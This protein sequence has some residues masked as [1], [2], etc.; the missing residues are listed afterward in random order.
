[1]IHIVYIMH[2]H[3]LCILL[4]LWILVIKLIHEFYF[5]NIITKKNDLFY[6]NSLLFTITSLP[7]TII[8]SIIAPYFISTKFKRNIC[9]EQRFSSAVCIFPIGILITLIIRKYKYI[10]IVY[11][12]ILLLLILSTIM[13]FIID[14]KQIRKLNCVISYLLSCFSITNILDYK[15]N[16]TMLIIF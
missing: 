3:I 11:Y 14:N 5:K 13:T 8:N 15:L 10:R 7:V 12:A 4:S 16:T 6:K 2:I 1:M 9:S